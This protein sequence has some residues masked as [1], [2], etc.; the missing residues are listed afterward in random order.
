MIEPSFKEVVSWIGFFKFYNP[1]SFFEFCVLL[2][3]CENNE[4][5][6]RFAVNK[7]NSLMIQKRFVTE[8]GE[9]EIKIMIGNHD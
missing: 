8:L 5:K 1:S 4:T 9:R 7:A 6:E 3:R 2:S